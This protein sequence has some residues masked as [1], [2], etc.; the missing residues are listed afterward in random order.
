MRISRA[1]TYAIG[2]L[3]QLVDA[4]AGVPVPCSRLA[5][6]GEMP[7]RFLLQVLRGLVNSGLLSSTRGIDGGYALA[8]PAE[9]ISLLQ[10]LEATDGPLSS[11]LPP[12]ECI[13]RTAQVY[14]Q[15]ALR[16]IT[17]DTCRQLAEVS[18]ADLPRAPVSKETLM[19][20]S[21]IRPE[22]D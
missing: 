4:P 9:E 10:I 17:A 16:R 2:A 22:G 20:T 5:K 8:R 15:E 6:T 19:P 7:E 1:S 3:L 14:L 18:L 21:L 13:P 11:D 12:L